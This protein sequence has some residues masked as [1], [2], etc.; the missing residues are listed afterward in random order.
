MKQLN[1][2]ILYGLLLCLLGAAGKG[3]GQE[4]E[5]GTVLWE[6]DPDVRPWKKAQYL[7]VDATGSVIAGVYSAAD[8]TNI[9]KIDKNGQKIWSNRVALPLNSHISIS[10]NDKIYLNFQNHLIDFLIIIYSKSLILENHI[11][12]NF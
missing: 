11:L 8:Q 5:P 3:Y 1:N 10:S 6:Y 2:I 7:S 9:Y 4:V 12:Y